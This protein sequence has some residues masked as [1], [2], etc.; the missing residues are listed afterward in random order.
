MEKLRKTQVEMKANRTFMAAITTLVMAVTLLASCRDARVYDHFE[1]VNDDGWGRNDTVRF[2][3][4][5]QKSCEV[6]VNLNL[7]VNHRFPYRDLSLIVC[8]ETYPSGN[9]DPDTV[10]IHVLNE[11]G[12]PIGRMGITSASISAKVKELNLR[13][14]DSLYVTVH[15]NMRRDQLTGVSD[16]G[17]QLVK[18]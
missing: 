16:V 10:Q 2:A 18:H 4:S 14:G 12:Q 13:D 11:K 6:D 5:R 9:V 17:L 15:H 1:P 3:I 7:R 8:Y